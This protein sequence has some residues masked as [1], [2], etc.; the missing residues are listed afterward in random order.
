MKTRQWYKEWDSDKVYFLD[1]V[2]GDSDE[3]IFY[4]DEFVKNFE[5]FEYEGLLHIYSNI[6]S[7]ENDVIKYLK[8]IKER[9]KNCIFCFN[10]MI[11][12]ESAIEFTNS[13]HVDNI[14]KYMMRQEKLKRITDEYK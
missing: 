7:D 5:T 14:T 10:M 11:D 6:K 3:C 1:I 9:Y 12:M 2:C 8:S 13:H 4:I